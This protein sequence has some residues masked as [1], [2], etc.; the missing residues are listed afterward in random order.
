M[1]VKNA[2]FLAYRE[3]AFP[4]TLQTWK[5]RRKVTVL[6]VIMVQNVPVCQ[7]AILCILEHW[8][9]RNEI[10]FILRYWGSPMLLSLTICI[11]R[12]VLDYMRGQVQY[13]DISLC[14]MFQGHPQQQL[15]LF[16]I[17]YHLLGNEYVLHIGSTVK[18][19]RQVMELLSSP[20]SIVL[21]AASYT[22]K[23]ITPG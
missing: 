14:F 1:S 2:W 3:I 20:T 17:S 6:T 10:H 7:Y 4:A 12:K 11:H 22:T 15:V 19:W 21:N 13:D 16:S 8:K 9:S 5:N 18:I 23:A